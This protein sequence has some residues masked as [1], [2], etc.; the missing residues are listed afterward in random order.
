[1]SPCTNLILRTRTYLI[2]VFENNHFIVGNYNITI[3]STLNNKQYRM[4][5]GF[6]FNIGVTFLSPRWR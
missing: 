2:D 3:G 6:L 1:M 5:V 4:V